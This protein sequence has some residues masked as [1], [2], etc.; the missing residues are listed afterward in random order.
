MEP[1]FAAQMTLG[2][3]GSAILRLAESTQRIGLF[4]SVSD[5]RLTTSISPRDEGA[6]DVAEVSGLLAIHGS[7]AGYMEVVVEAGQAMIHAV[8]D[9]AQQDG[10]LWE[11]RLRQAQTI[12][13]FATSIDET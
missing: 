11:S 7:F 10:Y 5:V 12:E 9:V 8:I 13:D 2:T 4:P 6:E 1:M 3:L